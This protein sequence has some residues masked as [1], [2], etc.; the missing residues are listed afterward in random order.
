MPVYTSIEDINVATQQ[1]AHLQELKAY[2]IKGWPQ[3]KEV[4]HSMTNKIG[5]D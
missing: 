5:N 2:V 1:N 4:E 3:K